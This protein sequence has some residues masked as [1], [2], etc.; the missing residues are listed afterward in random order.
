[1]SLPDIKQIKG[2]SDILKRL[3]NLESQIAAIAASSTNSHARTYDVTL[4]S[5][6]WDGNK[7]LI[8]CNH[9]TKDSVVLLSL[10]I[11]LPQEQAKAYQLAD[12]YCESQS[13]GSILLVCYGTL[14]QIDILTTLIIL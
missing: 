13:D 5:D 12:I 2:G 9:I 10:K 1:M 8:E 7:Y 3:E 14:P 6:K 11:G 4:F